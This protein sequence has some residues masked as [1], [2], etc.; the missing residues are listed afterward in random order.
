MKSDPSKAKDNERAPR[1]CAD[2]RLLPA[3]KG[4]PYCEPCGNAL[5]TLWHEDE[6]RAAQ[7]HAVYQAVAATPEIAV[8]LAKLYAKLEP[9]FAAHGPGERPRLP[10]AAIREVRAFARRHR[11]PRRRGVGD[12]LWSLSY[13][14][15]LRR[16]YRRMS[17]TE[18]QLPQIFGAISLAPQPSGISRAVERRQGRVVDAEAERLTSGYPEGFLFDPA[19]VSERELRERANQIRDHLLE[20]GRRARQHRAADGKWRELPPLYRKP[21]E[22]LVLGERV[23]RRMRGQ[24]WQTI[25]TATGAKTREAV[26]LSVEAWAAELGIELPADERRSARQRE[27]LAPRAE[28]SVKVR[29]R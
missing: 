27:G 8:E 24:S 17:Y 15:E 7:L 20:A 28:P 12:V 26:R 18:Q 5:R 10:L 4:S 3:V 14:S 25:A 21:G 2:C 1:R 19:T 13:T 11:L 6:V 23:A 22:L 29:V 16:A 9:L